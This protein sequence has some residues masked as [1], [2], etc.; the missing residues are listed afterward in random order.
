MKTRTLLQLPYQVARTPLAVVDATLA[1]R[2]PVDSPPR[3][4]FERILGSLDQVAGRVLN[5]KSVQ[6]RGDGLRAHAETLGDA[7]Q[8][9]QDAAERRRAAANA[10][11]EAK[12][13]AS[14]LRE[15][16]QRDQSRG[17]QEAVETEA[18]EKQ[19]ATRRARALATTA[20]QRADAKAAAELDAVERKRKL[21]EAR[22]TARK[23]RAAA[24]AKADLDA[25]AEKKAAAG[26]RRSDAAQLAKLTEAKQQARKR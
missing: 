4:A 22:A 12:L 2:L 13:H 24:T 3:L 9:E 5:D 7:V 26:V 11:Q 19:A 10:V 20:K 15:G 1:K 17:V 23:R 21:A 6:R 14:T 18:K 25:A 16:A 8:L